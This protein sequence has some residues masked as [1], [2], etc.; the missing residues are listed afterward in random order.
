MPENPARTFN[1]SHCR[2]LQLKD[3]A[4]LIQVGLL[5]GQARPHR[6]FAAGPWLLFGDLGFESQAARH[7]SFDCLS[8]RSETSWSFASASF[9]WACILALLY[10]GFDGRRGGSLLKLIVL[11]LDAEVS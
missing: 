6:L 4:S 1:S 7:R 11:Q 8:T 3:C 5:D 9:I 2:L 10:S